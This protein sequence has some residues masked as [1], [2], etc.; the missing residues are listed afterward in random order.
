VPELT[1]KVGGRPMVNLALLFERMRYQDVTKVKSDLIILP[2]KAS[3]ESLSVIAEEKR[4]SCL[5]GGAFSSTVKRT[6]V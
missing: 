1:S 6:A 2:T 3:D 5:E 4:Q